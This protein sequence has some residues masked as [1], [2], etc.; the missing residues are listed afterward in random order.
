MSNTNRTVNDNSQLD[1]KPSILAVDQLASEISDQY[2]NHKYYKWYCKAIY[3][4]GIDRVNQL[5]ASCR[6][7]K[8][9]GPLFSKKV[10]EAIH[11][12][13]GKKRLDEMKGQYGKTS[14]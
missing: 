1:A 5:R 14:N 2:G 7:S 3:I 4:L 11:S 6:D 10:N 9:P 8:Q 13:M 12:T